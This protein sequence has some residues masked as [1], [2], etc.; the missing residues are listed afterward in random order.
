MSRRL[1]NR[2][3]QTQ[4]IVELLRSRSPNWVSLPEVLNLRIS[5]YA[6]RIYQARHEWGLRIEN[7]TEIVNGEKHSYFRLLEPERGATRELGA[8]PLANVRVE[9]ST[10]SLF[11]DLAP[12]RYPD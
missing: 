4:R 11:G 10:D 1:E 9:R 2:P 3:T 5:Q 6:A 12:E 8:G 7:R